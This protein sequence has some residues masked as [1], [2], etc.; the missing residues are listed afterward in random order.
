M[1]QPFPSEKQGPL[2]R[3]WWVLFHSNRDLSDPGGHI[4]VFLV[5]KHKNQCSFSF[6]A[7][8]SASW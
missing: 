5:F 2:R 1:N 3:H 7:W 6:E 4:A 8:S